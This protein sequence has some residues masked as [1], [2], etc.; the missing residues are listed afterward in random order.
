MQRC[1]LQL[2]P[3]RRRCPYR[4]AHRGTAAILSGL[5]K[6]SD[7]KVHTQALKEPSSSFK[8]EVA[9]RVIN[10]EGRSL[11]LSGTAWEP[12]CEWRN[13]LYELYSEENG[14][15]AVAGALRA[16]PAADMGPCSAA[17]PL[18]PETASPVTLDP[19]R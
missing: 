8:S 7:A 9:P 5:N 11:R 12:Y 10:L 17:P 4:G 14:T 15:Q 1:R 3:D 2:S 6:Y 16:S 18:H 13:L 19:A